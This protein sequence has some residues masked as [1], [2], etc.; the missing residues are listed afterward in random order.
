MDIKICKVLGK[1]LILAVTDSI[2]YQF[3]GE[4]GLKSTLEE[5]NNN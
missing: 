4:F 3:L 1:I 2:L 5:Y